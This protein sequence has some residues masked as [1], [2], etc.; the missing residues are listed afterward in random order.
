M[1]T[2]DFFIDTLQSTKKA[3]TNQIYKDPVLN[4]AANDY[5]DAQTQFAKM[6]VHNTVDMVKYSVE[7]ISKCL[8]PQK[9]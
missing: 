8:F 7:S 3:L 2:P 1:F 5:I 4:K 6:M 9:G